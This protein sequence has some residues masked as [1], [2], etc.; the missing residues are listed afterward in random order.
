MFFR[1]RLIGFIA[2]GF[3]IMG[4]FGMA[5]SSAYHAGWSQGYVSGQAAAVQQAPPAAAAE[6]ET[7]APAPSAPAAGYNPYAAHHGYYGYGHSPFGW[8]IGGLFK[9][10]L[11][12][13]M[14]KFIFGFLFW[15]MRGRRHWRRHHRHG[16]HGPPWHKG[17][18]GRHGEGDGRSEKERYHDEH[19][20]DGPIVDL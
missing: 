13:I 17:H 14:L 10:F 1:S 3:L 9:L 5:R 20:P 16:H 11:F 2:A 18:H 15:G 8:F 19:G 4:L 6:G 12:L 7:A